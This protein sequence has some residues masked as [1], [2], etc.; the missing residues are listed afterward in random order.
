[1]RQRFHYL[2]ILLLLAPGCT[3]QPDS[4]TGA[5]NDISGTWSGDYEVGGRRESIG[6]ELQWDGTKLKGSVQAGF[7]SLPI[8]KASFK[9]DNGAITIEF[10]AQGPGG[11]TVHYVVD[12][13]I[14][15]DTMAGA[16]THDD[17]K[18][19]FRVTKE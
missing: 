18:G 17:Q 19:D 16:W 4:S 14:T 13:K 1:M 11:R 5:P 7:R 6:V 8:T 3:S 9:P 12:G 15:G 10:D 2:V